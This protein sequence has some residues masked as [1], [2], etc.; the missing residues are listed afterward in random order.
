VVRKFA[1]RWVVTLALHPENAFGVLQLWDSA[2]ALSADPSDRAMLM[3]S[4]K[5]YL[6][7]LA[8]AVVVTGTAQLA[9]RTGVLLLIC[10]LSAWAWKFLRA[11]WNR[12]EKSPFFI[13]ILPWVLIP[14][15]VVVLL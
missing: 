10:A 4:R 15:L 12:G 9:P 7:L 3:S 8:L 6:I 1:L 11:E 5:T 13:L 14:L 2:P